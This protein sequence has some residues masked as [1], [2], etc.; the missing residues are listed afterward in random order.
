MFSSKIE[1]LEIIVEDGSNSEQRYEVT[2]LLE[3]WIPW[4]Q[5]QHPWPADLTQEPQREK[6]QPPDGSGTPG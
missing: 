1:V 2:N 5:A 4:A 3:L 6:A